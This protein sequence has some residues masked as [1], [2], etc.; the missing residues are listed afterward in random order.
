MNNAADVTD[1]PIAERFNQ[2]VTENTDWVVNHST[3]IIIA[4]VLGALVFAALLGLKWFSKRL[5]A[6]DPQN[7]N[8][9]SVIGKALSRTRTWFMI[10]VAANVIAGYAHAPDDLATTVRFL[11]V[12]ATTLQA[13]VFTRAIIIG[14]IEH[15]AHGSAEHAALASAMGIIRLLVTV[16]L[17]AVATILI[18]S[19]LGVN[20][21]GLI[22]GLG[23]GGIAIGLAAQGIFADL[24]AA[25]AILFDRPFGK[26]DSIKYDNT[27]GTVEDIGLK[28]TRI[29]SLTGEQI[30]IANKQLLEKEIH[31]LARLNRRRIVSTF[32]VIY[33]VPPEILDR[34]PEMLSEVIS[35]CSPAKLVRCGLTG[36]GASSVDYELQ[37]DVYSEDYNIV[38]ATRHAVNIAILR[39]FASE[40]IEFAYPTQTAFTAAPDGRYIMPY[41]DHPP[42]DPPDRT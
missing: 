40:G 11:F 36:F 37:Y 26:G 28:S 42:A 17:F 21:T 16:V 13:A 14:V 6:R 24:F 23:V 33:Q 2:I 8:W 31:N 18:L 10:A 38:F 1:P 35:K 30:I 39:L 29:R 20:V 4:C 15:R 5:Y 25:L 12:I 34:I 41:S 9:Q 27:S 32:G 19:N 3:Q 22:A 7:N